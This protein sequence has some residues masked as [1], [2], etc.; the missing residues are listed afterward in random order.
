MLMDGIVKFF[1][2]AVGHIHKII[3]TQWGYL[4]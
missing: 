3:L 2:M 4:A 1:L